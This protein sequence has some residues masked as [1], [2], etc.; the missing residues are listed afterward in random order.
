ML[1]EPQHP[2][3]GLEGAQSEKEAMTV[4]CVDEMNI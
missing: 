2:C 3:L 1:Q 4:I